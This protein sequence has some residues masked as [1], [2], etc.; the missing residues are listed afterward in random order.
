MG[1]AG[2]GGCGADCG[3]NSEAAQEIRGLKRHNRELEQTTEVL[4][5][6][7]SISRGSSLR[8]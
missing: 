7:A 6:A 2:R 4:K 3:V 5:A 8:R 1:A